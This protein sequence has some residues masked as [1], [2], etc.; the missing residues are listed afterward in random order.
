MTRRHLL[1]NSTLFERSDHRG[2]EIGVHVLR[3]RGL[4]LGKGITV[5]S[6]ELTA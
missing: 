2:G 1:D 6:G 5:L 4:L 3:D